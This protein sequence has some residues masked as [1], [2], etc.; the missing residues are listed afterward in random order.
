M[1]KSAVTPIHHGERHL[2]IPCVANASQEKTASLDDETENMLPSEVI[3]HSPFKKTLTHI[4]HLTY[5]IANYV[6]D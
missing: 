4:T 6:Q 5:T 2:P 1:V 3:G